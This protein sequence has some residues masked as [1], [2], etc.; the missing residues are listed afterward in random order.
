MQQQRDVARHLDEA[1]GHA[2]D[3]PVRRQPQGPHGEA[4][5]GRE[6]DAAAGDQQELRQLRPPRR[7]QWRIRPGFAIIP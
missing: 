7:R 4:Q 2:V 3:Q 5:I 1:I 6:H